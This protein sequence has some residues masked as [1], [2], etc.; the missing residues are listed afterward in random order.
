MKR[1]VSM[2]LVILLVAVGLM[3]AV[4]YAI[5]PSGD[6]AIIELKPTGSESV[7]IENISLITVNLQNYIIQYFNKSV[8]TSFNIPTTSQQLPS[9]SLLP[10]QSFLLT[11][12][13]IGTCGASGVSSLGISLSDSSGYLQV[14]KAI[15]AGGAVTFTSQDKVSW[16]STSSGADII[17]VPSATTDAFATW[18][19]KLSDGSWNKYEID[20]TPCNLLVT[21]QASSGPTYVDWATGAAAPSEVVTADASSSSSIPAAD[22]G[23]SA[24]QVTELLPNPAS[25]QSDNEDEFIELYNPNNVSFDLSGFKLQVGLT[26]V[27][28]YTFPSGTLL[29]AK[30]FKAFYSLDTNLSMSNTSGQARLIDPAGTVI[31]QSEQYASAKEGQSWALADGSW[32]WA[33]PTPDKANTVMVA[34]P[35]TASGKS[36][37]TTL[38][39]K[40]ATNTA[41]TSTKAGQLSSAVTAQPTKVHYWTIAVIGCAALLYA[42]YEYRNDLQNNLY[43]FRRYAEAR[44]NF[45]RPGEVAFINRIK[46]RPWRRKNHAGKRNSSRAKKPKPG[47]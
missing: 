2:F 40:G 15:S 6:L 31:G 44:R 47:K 37:T 22:V 13:S 24:P 25:P 7:V 16:T 34:S 46:S 29:P 14:V 26:T 10:Q 17:S 21:V 39:I 32:Y 38:A 28:N 12:D 42:L 33:D 9:F 3:S 5:A 27:H 19:R 35:A 23:L 11:G 20:T 8:P 41:Q 30:S 4:G 43:R 36:A 1:L 18:Y 45:S